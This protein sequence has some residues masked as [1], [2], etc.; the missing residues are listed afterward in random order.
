MLI[1]TIKW[2][3]LDHWRYS[4]RWILL[5]ALAAWALGN[6]LLLITPGFSFDINGFYIGFR[7]EILLLALL[8]IGRF[9]MYIYPII[10]TVYD[11][12]SSRRVSE[13]LINR[14]YAMTF[15][16]KLLFNIIAFL[17]G[18]I[19]SSLA[20]EGN[21]LGF[22][23]HIGADNINIGVIPAAHSQIFGAALLVPTTIAFYIIAYQTILAKGVS[24]LFSIEGIISLLLALLLAFN[25]MLN[26]PNFTEFALFVA[27]FIMIVYLNEKKFEINA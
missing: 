12:V 5:G 24:K 9:L 4:I 19:I 16:V 27:A 1:N 25:G 17:L 13:R 8:F 6:I 20:P 15:A 21:L 3:A 11:L 7:P 22:F 10:C 23:E 18:Y 14:P 26:L 2:D